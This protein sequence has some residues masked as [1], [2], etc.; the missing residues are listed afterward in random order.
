MNFGLGAAV[1]IIIFWILF[2]GILLTWNWF[3]KKKEVKD[4]TKNN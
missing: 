3:N 1:L 2:V 4:E